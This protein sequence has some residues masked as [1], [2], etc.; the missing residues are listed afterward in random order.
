MESKQKQV[1]GKGKD[2]SKRQQMR[3][4]QPEVAQPF[5]Q[6]S[7]LKA[8]AFRAP[9]SHVKR[10]RLRASDA[11]K[12]QQQQQEEEQEQKRQQQQQQQSQLKAETT[13]PLSC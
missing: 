6:L 13:R 9:F 3:I 11:N 4:E 1:M 12:L 8:T 2:K 5:W 10:C 7:H